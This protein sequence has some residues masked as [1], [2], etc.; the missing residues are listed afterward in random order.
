MLLQNSSAHN[1]KLSPLAC[2]SQRMASHGKQNSTL[3]TLSSSRMFTK[4]F[5]HFHLALSPRRRNPQE[6]RCKLTEICYEEMLGANPGNPLL[7]RNYAKFLHEVK[8]D[9]SKAEE[10]YE[11]AILAGPA[12]GEVLSLYAQLIWET[13]KDGDRAQAYFDRAVQAA[14]EDCYVIASYANFLWT[15]EESDSGV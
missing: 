11:R 7:L 12:D 3:H 8:E 15:S 14:P 9:S 6:C 10:F 13:H 4:A 2:I 1:P 5:S